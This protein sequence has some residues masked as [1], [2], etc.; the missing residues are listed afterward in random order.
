MAAAD[1]QI[2][3]ADYFPVPTSIAMTAEVSSEYVYCKLIGLAGIPGTYQ[4]AAIALRFSFPNGNPPAGSK[5]EFEIA[6]KGG[7]SYKYVFTYQTNL[8]FQINAT[9]QELTASRPLPGTYTYTV[10]ARVRPVD[11]A[12]Q[13]V[14]KVM[15]SLPEIE[16]KVTIL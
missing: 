13:V 15:D 5:Y 16:V 1:K 14:D 11:S 12:G 2:T 8:L 7:G 10:Y 9:I 4:T 3:V 6:M